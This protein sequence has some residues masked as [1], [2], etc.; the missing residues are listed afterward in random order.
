VLVGVDEEDGAA[1]VRKKS[2]AA[3]SDDMV[4]L[5][6]PGRLWLGKD[7]ALSQRANHASFSSL[8]LP[9]SA[10]ADLGKRN[11][12]WLEFEPRGCGGAYKCGGR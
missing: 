7:G 1:M 5:L 4:R 11:P 8:S 10:A 3:R 2:N 9:T 6:P 12:N